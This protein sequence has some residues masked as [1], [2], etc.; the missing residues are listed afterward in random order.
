[1]NRKNRIELVAAAAATAA[2]CG[3][4]IVPTS[5]HTVESRQESVGNLDVARK[6]WTDCI[7]AA[8]PRVDDP[9]S[10]SVVVARVAMKGCSDEYSAM[11]RTLASTC[12]RNPDC[13]RDTLAKAER[14]AT[15]AAT[16]DVVNARVHVA[17]AQV[18]KCE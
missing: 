12:G 1:M 15:Q 5:R 17:G 2:L 13:T 6:A 11:T 3:C 8:I 16:E 4:T 7:Q 9:H 14:V 10:S 18:L